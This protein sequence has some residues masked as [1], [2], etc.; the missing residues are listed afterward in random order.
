MHRG[1]P[2]ARLS[3]GALGALLL[4][5]LG[6]ALGVAPGLARGADA[7]VRLEDAVARSLRLP[8]DGSP[9]T[10]YIRVPDD[11]EALSIA[12]CS[13][14][15]VDLF[16][17]RGRPLG[18]ELAGTADLAGRQDGPLEVIRVATGEAVPLEPGDWHVA[19]VA[20]SD[21]D[22]VASFEVVAFV[23]RGRGTPTILPGDGSGR[24]F[25]VHPDRPELRTFLPTLARSL[26]LTIEGA[27]K[28]QVR[29]RIDGPRDARRSGRAPRSIVLNRADS[30]AGAYVLDLSAESGDT[31]PS[32]IRVK[33][34]W[35]AGVSGA[36][37]PELRPTVRPGSSLTLTLGG[38]GRSTTRT[39]RIPVAPRTGGIEIE[40]SNPAGTDVDLYVRRGSPLRAGDDDAD[41]FALS[42]AS[43]ERL[44]LG[45]DRA[46]APGIYY[47]EIVLVEGKGPVNVTVRVQR[48]PLGTRRGTWGTGQPPTI[49]PGRW[50]RGS[51]QAGRAGV[52]WYALTIP[53]GTRSMHAVLLEASAPL[54]LVIARRTDGSIMRRSLTARVDERIEHVFR[55]GPDTPR[56]FVLGVMNRNALADVVDF[57]LSLS[58]NGPPA[59]P[60]DLEWPPLI[61]WT[62]RTG[63]VR[64]AAS[65]VEL[66]VRGN[67][68][69]SGTC[70]TPRGRILTCRHVL[71]NATGKGRIQREGILV[72]F[73]ASLDRPPVQSYVARVTHDDATRD[74]AMLEIT[75]DV[76]GRKLPTDLSLPWIPLG[77][78]TK[79]EL[80]DPVLVFGYPSEG[81]ERSRTPIIL[82]R[83]SVSGFESIGGAPRWIKTDAWIGLGHSGGSLVD[84][85]MR[86]V[87]I[88]AATLGASEEL[89][90]AVP[91]SLLPAAWKLRILKDQPK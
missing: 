45:G 50:I 68:G 17:R 19:V 8:S 40:A 55:P 83:G 5:S 84:S 85:G 54:D 81:S 13:A 47:C 46:L 11:A 12:V 16:V 72:A 49:Q 3:T 66:T 34:R 75:S 58:L 21:A 9:W 26:T 70:V 14:R 25:D 88:P 64:A 24:Y 1:R 32:R 63:L 23:D 37:P 44:Y 91:I 79:L 53:P 2:I 65:T 62:G 42:S 57:R 67:A 39:V 22:R 71:E 29:Y 6:L 18:E 15:N 89:G 56:R 28:P 52:T 86:L 36:Q 60:S 80:G 87:G 27:D 61:S 77:D 78:F 43:A 38:A 48:F 69:G 73:P 7:P 76:F 74:L 90:L 4:L 51:I 10:G 33:A 30:P 35:D 41:Y 59:L 82:T 20:A 31:L